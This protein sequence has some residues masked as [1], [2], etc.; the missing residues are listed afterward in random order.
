MIV[1]PAGRFNVIEIYFMD[2][3]T[4]K[5]GG[6]CHCSRLETC[7]TPDYSRITGN[8]GTRTHMSGLCVYRD[9]VQ[10]AVQGTPQI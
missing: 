5:V 1:T 10:L 9:L 3:P 7:P 6:G 8:L 2:E 4:V